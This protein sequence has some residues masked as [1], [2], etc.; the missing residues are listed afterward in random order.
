VG[1]YLSYKDFLAVIVNPSNKSVRISLNIEDGAILNGIGSRKCSA[2]IDNTAP[3]SLFRDLVPSVKGTIQISVFLSGFD[4]L[5]TAYDSQVLVSSDASQFAKLGN[6]FAK[7]ELM[8]TQRSSHF[9]KSIVKTERKGEGWHTI[10]TEAALFSGDTWQ[11]LSVWP[12][13]PAF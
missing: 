9:A 5:F 1:K 2:N 6:K 8:D 3:R 13:L 12:V 7:R 10:V 11:F 4:Q